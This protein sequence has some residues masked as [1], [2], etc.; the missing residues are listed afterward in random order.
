MRRSLARLEC[1]PFPVRNGFGH[2]GGL[3]PVRGKNIEGVEQL[4]YACGQ[5]RERSWLRHNE[6]GGDNDA[7]GASRVLRQ[8]EEILA[9]TL[10][11]I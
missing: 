5:D 7:G 4:I 2:S 10:P 3:H 1:L 8:G 9:A 11:G 6:F